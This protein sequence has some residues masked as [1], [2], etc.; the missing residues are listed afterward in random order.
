MTARKKATK[1]PVQHDDPMTAHAPEAERLL[2]GCLLSWPDECAAKILQLPRDAWYSETHRT[3]CDAARHVVDVEQ[4]SAVSAMTV[5]LR[6]RAAG[7]HHGIS[8][9]DLARME[10]EA[11]N[12]YGVDV[13]IAAVKDTHMRRD[14]SKRLRA[15]YD[16][17]LRGEAPASVEVGDGVEPSPSDEIPPGWFAGDDG[18]LWREG[19]PAANDNLPDRPP[20]RIA[21]CVPSIVRRGQDVASGEHQL[22]LSWRLDGRTHTHTCSRGIVATSRTITSLADHGLPVTSN[23]AGALVDYFAAAEET[24]RLPVVRMARSC[25]WHGAS[26]LRGAHRHGP[27]CPEWM[28]GDPVDDLIDSVAESGTLTQWSADVLPAIERFPVLRLLFAVTACTPLLQ[29]LGPTTASFAVDLCSQAGGGKTS[30]LRIALSIWG[31]PSTYQQEWSGTR[32]GVERVCYALGNLPVALDDTK[33]A[34]SKTFAS[35]TVYDIVSGA[36]KLRGSIKGTQ[37]TARFRSVL[38]S[39]G[40]GPLSG[41]AKDAGGSRRRTLTIDSDPWGSRSADLGAWVRDLT[42]SCHL[43]YGHAGRA[44]TDRLVVMSADDRADLQARWRQLVTRYMLQLSQLIADKTAPLDACAQYLA[45]AQVSGEELAAALGWP[46]L[47]WVDRSL[48]AGLA[49]HLG[50]VDR[51]RAALEHA[52]SWLSANPARTMGKEDTREGK[53]VTP[54]QGWIGYRQSGMVG[55]LPHALEAELE[56]AGYDAAAARGAWYDR[57]WLVCSG[58][59]R[60]ARISYAGNRYMIVALQKAIVEELDGVDAGNGT[61]YG[62]ETETEYEE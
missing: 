43:H 55:F 30:A 57:G 1:T 11:P 40:E 29:L 3:I 19:R 54:S 2:I 25:G 10:S 17:M 16:A 62:T 45:T 37:K 41:S 58:D 4:A 46:D 6:M 20:Q 7:T 56:R 35:Q 33:K 50:E 22:T 23:T 34:A 60:Q 14:T 8:L 26:F 52:L 61:V 15:A 28:R 48:I 53:S 44:L 49:R 18:A 9:A 5:I 27:N 24:C 59:R 32:V 36:G 31:N 39:T 47:Q 13:A 12:A 42:H 21:P 38:L 51:G